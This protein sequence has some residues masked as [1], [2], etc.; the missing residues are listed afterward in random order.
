V[1]SE[2]LIK[3]LGEF[4]R[5]TKIE[6]KVNEELSRPSLLGVPLIVSNMV[7]EG[8][9]YIVSK[10]RDGNILDIKEVLL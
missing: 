6:R 10:D 7:P 8:K 4:F 9:A 1:I 2:I 3:N 5:K